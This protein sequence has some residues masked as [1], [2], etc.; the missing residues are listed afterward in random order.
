MLYL[1]LHLHSCGILI[2]Y[3]RHISFVDFDSYSRWIQDTL[4]NDL[5]KDSIDIHDVYDS[6]ECHL[7]FRHQTFIP[8]KVNV[9]TVIAI[10]FYKMFNN[11]KSLVDVKSSS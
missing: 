10:D 11:W 5:W 6:L 3:D 8:R 2:F 1:E 4:Y 7:L 9:F